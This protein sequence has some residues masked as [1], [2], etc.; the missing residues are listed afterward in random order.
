MVTQGGSF[1]QK[2]RESQ[3]GERENIYTQGSIHAAPSVTPY[4]LQ[5]GMM[6]AA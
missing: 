5:N 3:N 6:P 4:T 2:R 1:M